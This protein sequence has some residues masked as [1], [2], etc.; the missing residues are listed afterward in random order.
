[1]TEMYD[2][3][4]VGAGAM[5]SAA[6]W[7]VAR[8]GRSVIAFEQF[9]LGHDRGGS[10]GATRIFRVG[11]EQTDFLYLA[12]RARTLWTELASEAGTELLTRVGAVEHGMGEAA[13]EDFSALLRSRGVDHELLEAA[14]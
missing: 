6:A 7:A 5:G 10:H 9:E 12:E 11:T 14:A 8:S 13:A 2:V 1:M 4:I 3:A